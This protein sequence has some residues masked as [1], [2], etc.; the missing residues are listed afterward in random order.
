MTLE[1]RDVEDVRKWLTDGEWLVFTFE[2]DFCEFLEYNYFEPGTPKNA[3]FET[4]ILPET[5]GLSF[6]FRIEDTEEN[7][8]NLKEALSRFYGHV[9]ENF[10]DRLERI[11]GSAKEAVGRGEYCE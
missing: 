5:R 9:P 11:L 2:G 10:E 3:E 6:W 1:L 4:L 7:R 8:K